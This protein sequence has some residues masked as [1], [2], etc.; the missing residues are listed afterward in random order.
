MRKRAI[1]ILI[2]VG[3]LAAAI[4]ALVL[5]RH[6]RPPATVKL[7]PPAAAYLFFD[8]A[9][10]RRAAV[11]RDLPKVEFEAEYAEFVRQTGF[12][13]ERDL[14][15]AA[16]ALQHVAASSNPQQSDWRNT[17]VF[18]AKF[19]RGK[20]EAYFKNAA[21]GTEAYRNTTIYVIPLPGRTV[22]VA[23]L[24]AHTIA[25]TNTDGS[26]ILQGVIDRHAQFSGGTPDLI[27]TYYG[28]IPWGSLAWA[29]ARPPVNTPGGNARLELPGGLGIFLPPDT[30][31][32]ASLRYLGSVDF[33][34]Q[35][36]A[37]TDDAAR[38]VTD[39]LS[40]FLAL[41]RALQTSQASGNDADVKGFFDSIQVTLEGS[42]AEMQ[43]TVPA[44]FVKKLVAGGPA[45]ID[46][47]PAGPSPRSIRTGAEADKRILVEVWSGG[48]DGLTQRLRDALESAFKASKDFNLSS[49]KKP[50][51]L[52]VTISTH[53]AWKQIGARNQVLYTV[54]FASTDDHKI[55]TSTGSCW[56]DALAKGAAQIMKDA[57]LAA[58]TIH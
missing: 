9:T 33:R 34:A 30:V 20:I 7:L 55:G 49:G 28:N 37:T 53:V 26:Y 35:A 6:G 36:F 21:G 25:A 5:L 32:V 52:V 1:L 14:D 44:G 15:E 45:S 51:T 11:F 2:A 17:G 48:D 58:R 24:D 4:L 23:V 47:Q 40:A 27:H 8:V 50:G 12:N 29:I 16:F 39:Q 56:D 46:T 18:T 3:V 42:R 19:D 43:A 13:V 38:R 41:F 22:R 57:R 10:V 54:G 31:V